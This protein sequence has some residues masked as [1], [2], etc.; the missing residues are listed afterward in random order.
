M[1]AP[2]TE[3]FS[4]ALKNSRDV[5]ESFWGDYGFDRDRAN[6]L[7]A[8]NAL[9]RQR[10]REFMESGQGGGRLFS[11]SQE[12]A[13]H[14]VEARRLLDE[15]KVG[16]IDGTN[17]LSKID[18]NITTQYACAVGWITSQER[19]TPHITI[20][21]TIADYLRP[22]TLREAG[23]IE[24]QSLY[25]RKDEARQQESWPT[26]YREY[27]ERRIAMSEC[28]APIVIIDGPVFTQNLMSQSR[29]RDL[30]SKMFRGDKQ[31]IGVIKNLSAA[32]PKSVWTAASLN[33][34]EGYVVHSSDEPILNRYPLIKNWPD[35]KALN[36][37]V[38][39][40]YRPAEKAFSFEC[41]KAIVGKA[42]AILMEDTSPTINHELPVLLETIDAQL[43]SGFNGAAA[44]DMVLA[45]YMSLPG[46]Y[47]DAVDATDE[48]E[49]R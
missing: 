41:L 36:Q 47:Q 1:S 31:Y 16:A 46:G 3:V 48:R 19:G 8:S 40:V 14:A 37:F 43:R 2:E 6:N 15:G 44:R 11:I 42:L 10:V 24:W 49:Y 30:Y 38:R 25:N 21:E 35:V 9:L 32:E 5:S 17:A 22:E 27:Q 33:R 12:I 4:S 39:V 23:D 7:L 45:R 13:P 26:T 18:F 34:G 29:G 28:T 20:T